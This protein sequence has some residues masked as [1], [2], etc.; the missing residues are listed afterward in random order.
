MPLLD[1]QLHLIA[2]PTL[3]GLPA[4]PTVRL[5]SLAALPLVV[6][7]GS[8]GLRA[9]V[10]AAFSQAGLTPRVVLEVDGLAVLMDAVTA[11]IG[12]TVQPAA[13]TARVAQAGLLRFPI[14]DGGARRRSLLASLAD[15]E[16][17]PAA[18]ATRRVIEQ[19]AA[20]LAGEGRWPGASLHDS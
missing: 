13:A 9:V 10:N 14:A 8:H 18:Q 20:A 3:A 4:G 7:S 19:T 6:P 1:E 17:S 5:T 11:G 15:D 16:L 12:A 2:A